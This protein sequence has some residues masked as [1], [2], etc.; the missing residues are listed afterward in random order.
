MYN[1]LYLWKK[2]LDVDDDPVWKVIKILI[3]G[4][5]SSDNQAECMLRRTAGI[6]KDK[7]LKAYD[8][9]MNNMYVDNCLS[10]TEGYELTRK[11]ADD[12]QTTLGGFTLK[13]FEER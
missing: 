6:S 8:V 2:S 13:G 11:L 4:V 9:I 12:L 1:Q 3:Y 5:R 10:S 7:F